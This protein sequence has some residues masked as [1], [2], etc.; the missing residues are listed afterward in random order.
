MIDWFISLTPEQQVGLLTLILTIIGGVLVK[1]RTSDKKEIHR[2]KETP[3]LAPITC[4]FISTDK[5]RVERL[6]EN[7]RV[8]RETQIE[9]LTLVRAMNNRQ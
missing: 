5:E 1:G 4:G 2:P 7:L 3:A 6:E 9:T 8:I